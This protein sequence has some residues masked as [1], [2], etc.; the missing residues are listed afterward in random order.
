LPIGLSTGFSFK[1][2]FKSVNQQKS[3]VGGQVSVTGH[4]QT[5]SSAGHDFG[6]VVGQHVVTG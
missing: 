1:N 4:K 5:D 3:K 2:T 6:N